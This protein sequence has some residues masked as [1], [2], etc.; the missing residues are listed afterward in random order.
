MRLFGGYFYKV[1]TLIDT[2]LFMMLMQ[3]HYLCMWC[4]GSDV[5]FCLIVTDGETLSV[6]LYVEDI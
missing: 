6:F 4:S 5:F 1:L 2:A 3:W